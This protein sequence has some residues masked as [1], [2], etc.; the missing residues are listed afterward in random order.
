[1]ITISK[2]RTPTNENYYDF[3]VVKNDTGVFKVTPKIDGEVYELQDGDTIDLKISKT[4]DGEALVTI[5]ANADNEIAITDEHSE[6]LVVG[7]YYC[8]ITLNYA[9]GNRDTFIKIP[10]SNGSAI[11]NFHI[12]YGV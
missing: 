9:D 2:K 11:S 8:D 7:N 6:L 4:A 10:S 12:V 5:V 1:M 3:T